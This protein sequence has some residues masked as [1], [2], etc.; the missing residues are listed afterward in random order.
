MR[1]TVRLTLLGILLTGIGFAQTNAPDVNTIVGRMQTAMAG[2][3]HDRAFSVTREYTLAPEDPAKATKV[4]AEINSIPPGKKDYTITR[5]EGQAEKVVRKVLDH[6]VEPAEK[7]ADAELTPN[8]YEFAYAGMEPV[9]GHSCYVLQ[10]SARHDSKDT[11]NGKIWIDADSYLVRQL[12]GTPTKSPSWW[13]KD[14]QVTLHYRE[15]DGLWLQDR[16]QAVAGVRIV[17]KHTLTAR[18]LD[19]RTGSEMAARTVSQPIRTKRTRRVDPA[20]LG[21]GVFQHN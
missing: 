2:R 17:G 5:G 14:V 7:H 19:V 13:I 11:V 15:M 4:I 12:S 3:N 20:L 1:A 16:S 21:S 9:D 8:N 10:L 18:A 6:E